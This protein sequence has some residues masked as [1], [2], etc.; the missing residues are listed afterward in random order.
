MR[1]AKYRADGTIENTMVCN[2]PAFAAR[3]GYVEHPYPEKAAPAAETEENRVAK[4][5]AEVEALKKL[6]QE[7]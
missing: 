3:L 5:E 4:L 2:D 6:L 1:Y 7:K